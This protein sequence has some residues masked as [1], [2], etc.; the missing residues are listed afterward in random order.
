MICSTIISGCASW[1][2]GRR[3]NC[4]GLDTGKA[5]SVILFCRIIWNSL[6]ELIKVMLKASLD[7]PQNLRR[8]LWII[9]SKKSPSI[10]INSPESVMM[11]YGGIT[12]I[13]TV[14]CWRECGHPTDRSRLP[15]VFVSAGLQSSKVIVTQ[16]ANII[17]I[18]A[19]PLSWLATTPSKFCFLKDK[20]YRKLTSL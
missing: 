15:I 4:I 18:K 11:V 16:A 19:L 14:N 12:R 9:S 10:P 8:H 6:L 17:F 3:S 2:S 1:S 7:K 5:K 20:I 13:D